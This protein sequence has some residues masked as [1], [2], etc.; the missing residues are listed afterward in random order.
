[1]P[2]TVPLFGRPAALIR[3][4][5]P[6]GPPV[7]AG[8]MSRTDWSSPVSQLTAI[9]RRTDAA[10]TASRA[11]STTAFSRATARRHPPSAASAPAARL[12]RS[13]LRPAL[14]WARP[15]GIGGRI[16]DGLWDGDSADLAG[17]LAARVRG[18]QRD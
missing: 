7:T 15:D 4:P 1:M 13:Q 18:A 16:R 3:M 8:T 11:A 6:P 9:T 10:E 2:A 14:P 12:S 17:R 5:T